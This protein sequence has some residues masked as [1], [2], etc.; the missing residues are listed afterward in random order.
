MAD[1]NEIIDGLRKLG[2]PAGGARDWYTVQCKADS[3]KATIRIFDEIGWLGVSARTFAEELDALDV[4]EID[5]RLNS[6][7]GNAWDGIAIH[8]ALRAHPAKVTVTVDGVAA[9]AASAIAMAGDK[10]RMSRGA[11]MMV[12]EASGGSWGPAAMMR[13]AAEWLDVLSDSYADVY[14]ARAGGTAEEWRA[15]MVEETWY[16]ASEAVDAGLA[17]ELADAAPDPE[18][19]AR[20]H[21]DL[22]AYA[23]A[24]A[25]RD[26]APAPRI[27]TR[28]APVPQS[29]ETAAEAARRIHAA[30]TRSSPPGERGAGRMDPAKI[31]EALGLTADASDDEV[32]AAL[33]SAG[34]ATAPPEPAPEPDPKPEPTPNPAPVA[35]GTMT[36]DAQAWQ[37]QQ[38]QIRQ[39]QAQASRQRAAER[40]QVIEQAVA[41][42]KFA[43][44][45]KEHWARLWDHDPDGTRTVIEGLAKNVVPVAE[46][47]YGADAEAD[48]DDEFRQFFPPEPARKGR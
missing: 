16:K 15:V 40:D 6:P 36:I 37:E 21:W 42:G 24:Y 35:A 32:K 27:P 9:S 19:T 34:L 2:G 22:K 25:G 33:A 45:R 17:D 47:G 8:N 4:D 18:V 46:M 12:H 39:L 26:A 29:P 38:E 28:P 44:S 5:L 1:L 31:R 7:G 3:R 30:A 11:Q 23:Y 10:I 41:A 13:K 48:L 14:A 43:P 20:A